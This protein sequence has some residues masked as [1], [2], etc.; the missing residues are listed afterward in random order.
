[1]GEKKEENINV[2]IERKNITEI[3]GLSD[4]DFY[5]EKCNVTMGKYGKIPNINFILKHHQDTNRE[6]Y[7]KAV[8]KIMQRGD[9]R[10]KFI[11]DK[12]HPK[13]KEYYVMN[14]ER[15]NRKMAIELLG[16]P[17][18]QDNKETILADIKNKDF[19]SLVIDILSSLGEKGVE[20]ALK[21]E[22][23]LK[24]LEY[25]IYARIILLGYEKTDEE[26]KNILRK[27][28][29]NKTKKQ[30]GANEEDCPYNS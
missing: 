4:I 11:K 14:E 9:W 29:P 19:G 12:E 3:H 8:D 24:A 7:Q 20:N 17:L 21:G 15:P 18:I 22:L 30:E 23:L 5:A 26:I 16:N 6:P 28:N 25:G 1:M 27:Y 13:G 2:S 10:R